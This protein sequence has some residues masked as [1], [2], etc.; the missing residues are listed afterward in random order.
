MPTGDAERFCGLV[1]AQSAEV[2]QLHDLALTLVECRQCPERIVERNDV[3]ARPASDGQRFV[4]GHVHIAAAAFALPPR[5]RDVHQYPAH[6]L[7]GDGEEVRTALPSD[8]ARIDE[9][10]VGFVDE[11]GGLKRVA[12]PFT[13]H[14]PMREATELVMDQGYQPVERGLVAAV[15]RQ[16]Q[17]GD[18]H[19]VVHVGIKLGT[20]DSDTTS[21]AQSHSTN[22][23]AARRRDSSDDQTTPYETS[24][25]F[26]RVDVV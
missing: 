6:Q 24:A 14:V 15:P 13:P 19:P 7:G 9:P 25:W 16:Q 5:A 23:R 4:E 10:H 22:N 21:A 12:G 18:R 17:F 3:E 1:D 8:T 26:R 11:R 2:A 20:V